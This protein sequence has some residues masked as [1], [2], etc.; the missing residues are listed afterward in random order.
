[1]P[2]PSRPVQLRT[3]PPLPHAALHPSRSS[4][5]RARDDGRS[6]AEC[7]VALLNATTASLRAARV[8]GA[9]STV[10]DRILINASPDGR[11]LYD[12]AAGHRP[13]ERTGRGARVVGGGNVI[14]PA[15]RMAAGRLRAVRAA[16]TFA[17]GTRSR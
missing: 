17:T 3:P 2:G 16:D 11:D 1:M 5:V 15:C 9:A 7:A 8:T 13:P 12:L 10:D 4:V 6:H 14:A